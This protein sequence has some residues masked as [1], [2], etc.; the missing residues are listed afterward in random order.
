MTIRENNSNKVV[1]VKISYPEGAFFKKNM[2]SDPYRSYWHF[3]ELFINQAAMPQS[4]KIIYL[5][6]GGMSWLYF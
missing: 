3:K 6:H 4:S 2:D 1:F 5:R